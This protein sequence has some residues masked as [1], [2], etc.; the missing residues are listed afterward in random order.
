MLLKD[1]FQKKIFK[2]SFC[3]SAS[4]KSSSNYTIKKIKEVYIYIS[5][6]QNKT[7]RF[8]L[9]TDVDIHI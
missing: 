2:A 4:Y 3:F 7:A 8:H 1:V 9:S 6:R 5:E